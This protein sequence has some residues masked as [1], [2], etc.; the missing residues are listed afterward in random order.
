MPLNICSCAFLFYL[1]ACGLE[2]CG[3]IGTVSCY[4]FQSVMPL[5]SIFLYSL[6]LFIVDCSYVVYCLSLPVNPRPRIGGAEGYCNRFVLWT[7]GLSKYYQQ[8]SNHTRIKSNNSHL[9][10]PF[11]FKVMT[12][13]VTHCCHLTCGSKK[14]SLKHSLKPMTVE[15]QLEIKYN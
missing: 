11:C 9:L 10:K 7:L 13:F 2:F 15:S 5:I 14:S 4:Q 12:I 3:L 1:C 8:T 6:L